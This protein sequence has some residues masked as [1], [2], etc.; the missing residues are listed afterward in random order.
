[1]YIIESSTSVDQEIKMTNKS[2]KLLVSSRQ[3]SCQESINSL[4]N[5][6]TSFSSI[7]SYTVLSIVIMLTMSSKV[8]PTSA[9]ET[10]KLDLM[11]C[12]NHNSFYHEV[13]ICSM[14]R[15][16]HPIYQID[17]TKPTENSN[18]NESADSTPS[19]TVVISKCY[20]LANV[21]CF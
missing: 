10:A 1:M 17:F 21:D 18:L 16:G 19:S 20:N 15:P 12:L 8:I 5:T 11:W 2:H 13:K 7:T 4:S 6:K 14:L 9:S 3:K